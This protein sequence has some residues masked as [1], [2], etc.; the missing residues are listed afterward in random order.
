MVMICCVALVSPATRTKSFPL[1]PIKYSMMGAAAADYNV[2]LPC[3]AF[4]S[5]EGSSVRANV[6]TCTAGDASLRPS[7]SA[8]TRY[9]FS[10]RSQ[11]LSRKV[12][13]FQMTFKMQKLCYRQ[14]IATEKI[15]AWAC[16][17]CQQA[18]P[19][20][21]RKMQD[22]IVC[23]APQQPR[24]NFRPLAVRK[25]CLRCRGP[26]WSAPVLRLSAR[27]LSFPR[28][29]H[30]LPYISG[31]AGKT[32]ELSYR[33]SGNIQVPATPHCVCSERA[34]ARHMPHEGQR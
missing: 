14:H 34:G 31:G 24:I 17:M 15:F 5:P 16:G 23:T 1:I 21:C 12:L 30:R 32:E 33:P 4:R 18:F 22:W 20:W 10:P 9:A 6:S 29:C 25:R 27:H 8:N 28:P 7:A 3:V 13:R 2:R 19:I 11:A 26:G